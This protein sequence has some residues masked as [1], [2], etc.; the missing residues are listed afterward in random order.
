MTD[1]PWTD[2]LILE[3]C[4]LW[5]EGCSTAEIGRRLGVSKNAVIGKAHRLNLPAR[6]KAIIAERRQRGRDPR[7]VVTSIGT[8]PSIA[9][10]AE[11]FDIPWETASK[12]ASRQHKGWRFADEAPRGRAV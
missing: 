6:P 11:A 5:G 9:A 7:R 4:R 12:R 1:S 10:A 8:F 2:P 3:L